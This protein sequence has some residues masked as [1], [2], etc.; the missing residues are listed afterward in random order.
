VLAH[1][2]RRWRKSGREKEEEE[3]EEE[4]EEEN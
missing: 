2:N 4:E 3:K 1:V